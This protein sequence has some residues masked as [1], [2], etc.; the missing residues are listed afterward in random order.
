VR[1][2]AAWRGKKASEFTWELTKLFRVVE[3]RVLA[4]RT[5]WFRIE[6]PL[7]AR[8]HKPGQFVLVRV[9]EKGERFPLTI[10]DSDKTGGTIALVSQEVGKSTALLARVEEGECIL[11]VVGP[12]GRPT[13][14]HHYGRVVCVAGGIGVAPL[15]PITRGMKEAGN[16]VTV[17][18]GAR[19]KEL[20]I[21]REE[22]AS[23]CHRMHIATDDGSEGFHGFVS[24]LLEERIRCGEMF[25]HAVAIG[26]LPMMEAVCKV[27]RQ[28][29]IPTIVSL[30]PIM[31]DGTGMC[32]GCRVMVYGET[33]FA[34]VDGPEFDGFGVDFASLAHRLKMYHTQEQCALERM[35]KEA[36]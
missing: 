24:Q 28:Y 30:N 14:I 3:K 8:R 19:S 36:E 4:P 1:R 16:D 22:L 17:I 29:N 23:V 34:C 21:L 5:T 11:D 12:L 10:V 6:A 31:V 20:I 13:D 27:T 15:L 35:A 25:D 2:S 32:G 26:P 33:K 9:H 18:L 7:V